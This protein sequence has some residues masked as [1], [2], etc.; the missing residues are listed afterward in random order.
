MFLNG[1][2]FQS[3]FENEKNTHNTTGMIIIPNTV[4]LQYVAIVYSVQIKYDFQLFSTNFTF[5]FK[6]CFALIDKDN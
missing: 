3:S 1:I 5:S 6:Q 4:K 2:K